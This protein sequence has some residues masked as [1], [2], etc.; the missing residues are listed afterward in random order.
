MKKTIKKELGKEEGKE[1]GKLAKPEV[2][3]SKGAKK[4][5]DLATKPATKNDTKKKEKTKSENDSKL[6]VSPTKAR[7]TSQSRWK[8]LNTFPPARSRRR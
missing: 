7:S 8:T 6:K 4:K 1:E 5:V 2:V 3:N